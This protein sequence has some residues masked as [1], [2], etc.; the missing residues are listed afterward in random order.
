MAKN[1][2]EALAVLDETSGA[3]DKHPEKRM[4]AA[5]LVSGWQLAGDKTFEKIRYTEI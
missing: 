1:V 4:K 5:Y 2:D 3:V